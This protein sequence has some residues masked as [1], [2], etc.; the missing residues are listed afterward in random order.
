MTF[1]SGV[2]PSPSCLPTSSF[3]MLLDSS[4]EHKYFSF[5]GSVA[6]REIHSALSTSASKRHWKKGLKTKAF[7]F[8]G[9]AFQW[10]RSKKFNVYCLIISEFPFTSGEINGLDPLRSSPLFEMKDSGAHTAL[11]CLK[12]NENRKKKRRRHGRVKRTRASVLKNCLTLD[13]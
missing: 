11:W 13:V 6:G 7:S 10:K 1:L 3:C 5:F 8:W 4:S 2:D 9:K 12:T